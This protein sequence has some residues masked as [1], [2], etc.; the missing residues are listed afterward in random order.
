MITKA[1][2]LEP[3]ER[4]RGFGSAAAGC[5]AAS[6]CD[7]TTLACHLDHAALAVLDMDAHVLR[8]RIPD[9]V[10]EDLPR[11]P[12]VVRPRVHHELRVMGE[13]HAGRGHLRTLPDALPG[14]DVSD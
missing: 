12:G 1:W 8:M 7:V 5:S 11:R 14:R 13:S 6:R 9:L 3:A 10:H 2:S 4:I